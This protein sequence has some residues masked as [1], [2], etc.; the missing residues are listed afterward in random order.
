L[1]AK[2]KGSEI[3]YLEANPL[4]ANKQIAVLLLHGMSFSSKTWHELGTIQI[5]AALN[6]RTVAIDLPGFGQ[7]SKGS[8][9]SDGSK[10]LHTLIKKLDLIKPVIISPSYSGHF[11]LPYLLEYWN[12]M[13]GYVPISPVGDRVTPNYQCLSTNNIDSIKASLSYMPEKLKHYL[14]EPY[15]NLDCLKV[16][17]VNLSSN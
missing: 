14:K 16:C 2:Q 9:T 10:F 7:S 13:A 5:L 4:N 12:E 1:F 17:L 3:F 11:S 15:P 8:E 6:Y